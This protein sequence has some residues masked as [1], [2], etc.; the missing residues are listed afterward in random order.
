[1]AAVEDRARSSGAAY[2]ALA[3]RRAG[4]FYA[5]LGYRGSAGTSR[6]RFAI[7]GWPSG[8]DALVASS[9]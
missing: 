4:G 6:R 7:P 5:A 3:T 9:T 8:Q 1:M 2:V